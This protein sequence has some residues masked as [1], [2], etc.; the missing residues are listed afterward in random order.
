MNPDQVQDH[1]LSV[2]CL[3]CDDIVYEKLHYEITL[4]SGVKAGNHTQMVRK[5]GPFGGSAAILRFCVK[6]WKVI[7]PEEYSFYEKEYRSSEDYKLE[8]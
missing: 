3:V 4:K 5:M 1:V 2:A 7:A 8:S 6:C